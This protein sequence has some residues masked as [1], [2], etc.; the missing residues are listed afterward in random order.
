MSSRYLRSRA[1]VLD[2]VARGQSFASPAERFHVQPAGLAVGRRLGADP[3]DVIN[4][5]KSSGT[6]DD[7]IQIFGNKIRGGGPSGSGGG[8]MT[9]DS[10][11]AYIVVRDNILVDP[12]QYGIA[13]AGGHHVQIMDNKVFGKKQSFTTVGI[14]V[15]NQSKAPSHDHTVTGNQV[16]WFNNAGMENPY[17]DAEN[18]GT[19]TGW[20]D[21]NW[22]ADLD[23]KLL[24]M[25][26]LGKL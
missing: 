2:T 19:I 12:G 16:R 17:W 5:Y 3:E 4:I 24:P 13:I 9:G 15:W 1:S 14:Y 25:D 20:N 7:P 23:D 10:G 8:I 21:N 22:H 6:A 18:C 11:G 26:L